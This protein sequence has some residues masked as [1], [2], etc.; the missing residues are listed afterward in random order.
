MRREVDDRQDKELGERQVNAQKEILVERKVH[1]GKLFRLR[2]HLSKGK[3]DGAILTGDFFLEP[4]E[5]IE[6]L[7]RAIATAYAS[8][9]ADEA[10]AVLDKAAEGLLITGFSTDDLVEALEE[11]GGCRGG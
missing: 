7:E 9:D 1:G 6:R 2:I 8:A 10:R 4:E 11:A 3:A 5:G